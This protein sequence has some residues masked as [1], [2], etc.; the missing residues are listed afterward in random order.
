LLD[1]MLRDDVKLGASTPKADPSGDYAFAMFA[2]AEALKPGSR[3][4]QISGKV[5]GEWLFKGTR[6]PVKRHG[7][8]VKYSN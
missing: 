1:T 3:V 2:K 8:A 7:F 5:S 4:E 6:V